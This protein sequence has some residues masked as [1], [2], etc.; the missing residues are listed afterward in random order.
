[1]RLPHQPVAIAHRFGNHPKLLRQA[2]EAG[3]A[4]VETDVRLYHGRLEVRHAKTLGPIPIIWDRWYIRRYPRVP[5]V[6]DNILAALPAGLGIMLDL[7][8]RDPRMPAMILDALRRHPD[9]HPVMVSARFWDYL[10]SLREH[11]DLLLFHSVGRPWEL[12]RVR[13]LLEQRENDA[14]CVNYKLLSAE[15]VRSLKQQ[16]AMVSTWGINDDDRLQRCLEWGVDAIIT[17]EMSILRKIADPRT[18]ESPA[19]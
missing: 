2:A 15:R 8:G 10:P 17:D 11:P 1:M 6:L 9:A 3:A 16:V 18:L 19:S 4:Y 5:L 12:R 14:I 13:P 7:K